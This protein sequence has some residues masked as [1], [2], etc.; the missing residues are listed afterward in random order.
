MI[1]ISESQ[2]EF[3]SQDI[4]VN[5]VVLEDLQNNLLDHICCI[6]ENEMEENDDF[7]TFYATIIPRFFK[8][9]LYEIQ[10]ETD[11]LLTFKHFYAMKNTL[12]ISGLIAA[13][14]LFIGAVLKVM[15]LPGA[16]LGLLLGGLIFSLIFLPLMIVLKFQD[17]ET[18]I[19]KIVLSLGLFL[20]IGASIGVILKLLHWPLASIF[21]IWSSAL[22][23]FLFVPL[24][25]I[26]RYHRVELRFN[27][28]V[29]AVLMMAF[30]GMLFALMNLHVKL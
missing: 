26:T 21:M 28:T 27:T 22:F 3:I 13:P 18:I 29:N 10:V 25:F 30:G 17:E 9:S 1:K 6:I 11:N 5:G 4:A 14:L 20:G 12:K 8:S 16:S 7:A 19:D 24:Y 15:H 2:I 23:I